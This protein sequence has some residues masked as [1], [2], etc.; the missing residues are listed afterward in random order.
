MSRSF[1]LR[2]VVMQHV[3]KHNGMIK[4][5]SM[6]FLMNA[7]KATDETDGVWLYSAV[8]SLMNRLIIPVMMFHHTFFC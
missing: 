2:N 4:Q 5:N 7:D 6:R 3:L 8:M 1:S